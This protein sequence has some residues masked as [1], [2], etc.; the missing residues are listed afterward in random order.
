[1]TPKITTFRFY[2]TIRMI[3]CEGVAMRLVV[4]ASTSLVILENQIEFLDSLPKNVR[5][6]KIIFDDPKDFWSD[7]LH[8]EIRI[9]AERAA[10][11]A[12]GQF[13]ELSFRYCDWKHSHVF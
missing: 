2:E 8:W 11:H 4:Y 12:F 13:M 7:E 10:T 3:S 6:E 1:M 5:I 9:C